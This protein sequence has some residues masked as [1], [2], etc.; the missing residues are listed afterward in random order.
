MAKDN[1]PIGIA[2]IAVILSLIAIG[3][4]F[5]VTPT[6]T[7][8]AGS[9][10]QTELADDAV[11]SGKIVDGT[12]TD[13]DITDDGISKLVDNA[14]MLADLSTEVLDTI[15]GTGEIANNSVTSA[16]IRD[17]NVTTADLANDSV[18]NAKIASEA[19][20][21]DELADDAVT[22]AKLAPGAITWDSVTDKPWRIVAAAVVLTGDDVKES[23]NIEDEDVWW[24]PVA[25]RYEINITGVDY[26][27]HDYITI[28]TP[29]SS[30][31]RIALTSS[32]NN[33]L[34]VFII[35]TTTGNKV[36][37]NFC[38]VTYEIL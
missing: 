5:M 31:S 7:I 28:V 30:S 13:D 17:R 9:V 35:D 18:T 32:V 20:D 14:V 21:T 33:K 2:G 15:A 10:G 11:T 19:V 4:A 27:F 38:F 6:A 23:Y 1:V 24:N 22:S 26:Y 3:A 36:Q 25:T 16:K 37:E 8:G 12:I 29:V 34:L